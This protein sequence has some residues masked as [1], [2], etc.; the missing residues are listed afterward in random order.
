MRIRTRAMARIVVVVVVNDVKHIST[1]EE[2]NWMLMVHRL[3]GKSDKKIV[4]TDL[5]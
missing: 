4:N 2:K 1:K 5:C 3:P